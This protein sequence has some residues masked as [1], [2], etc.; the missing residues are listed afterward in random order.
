MF[1]HLRLLIGSD[2]LAPNGTPF[3]YTP[4]NGTLV[5]RK[6]CS[7]D[8]G[9]HI[10]YSTVFALAPSEMQTSDFFHIRLHYPRI[11]RFTIEIVDIR[12]YIP[13]VTAYMHF[14]YYI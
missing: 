7:I 13:G 9:Q 4:F 5:C 11:Y 2:L 6:T 10:G 12:F 8:C 14:I 1:S 3:Q